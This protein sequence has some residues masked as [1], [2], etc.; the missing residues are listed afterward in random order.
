MAH[1]KLGLIL[2][3]LGRVDEAKKCFEKSLNLDPN[4]KKT[5]EDYGNLLLKMNQHNKAI[6]Y[7][8]KGTGL[9]EFTQK[10]FKII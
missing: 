3:E 1:N 10:D 6:A 8:R 5:I 2:C 7:L 9:I 4:N